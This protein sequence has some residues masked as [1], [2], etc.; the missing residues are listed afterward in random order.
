MSAYDPS[1][2][3]VGEV[4]AHV[5]ENPA[6]AK[7]VLEA[8]KARGDDARKTLVASLE[9]IVEGQSE[10]PVPV[11]APAVTVEPAAAPGLLDGFDVSPD[12][13]YRRK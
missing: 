1:E 2:H 8:E 5:E 11:S 9:K 3:N 12:R 10:A 13:G 4:E 7:A 6:E